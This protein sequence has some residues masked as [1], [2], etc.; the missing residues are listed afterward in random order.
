MSVNAS[1]SASDRINALLDDASFVEVGSF[2][3]AR[4]TDFNLDSV[5][6][7]KDGVITGYGLINGRLVYVYSQDRSVLSGS[8]GEMHAKKIAKLYD[9]AMKMGAPVIGLIDCA[10]L[11][12]R[13]ATDALN[14]FGRLYMKQTMASGVVPQITAILG[15]CGGGVAVVPTLTDFTFISEESGKLFVNSPN[16]LDGNYTEKLDTAS[17]DYISRNTSLVDK[18]LKTDA[19]VL[20][21]IRSFID[22]LPSNCDEEGF[23][24]S[25]DDLNRTI[26]NLDSLKD[27][28]RAVIQ[29][30]ADDNLFYEIKEHFAPEMVTGFVRLNGFTTGVVANQVKDGSD[31]LTSA[32]MQKAARFVNFCDSFNVPVLTFTNVKGFTA[33]IDEEKTAA[34]AAARLIQTFANATV[35]KVNVITGV[36]YG[37]AFTAMNSKSVGADIVY[38]WPNAKVGMMDAEMAAKIIYDEEIKAADDKS[39]AV[40]DYKKQYEDIQ[41]SALSAARRGYVDD[42][43]EP[44]ATRKRVVAAFEMLSTKIEERPYKK[45]VS[46]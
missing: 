39:K 30:I 21:E 38:A 17:A 41:G 4:S 12:L 44:D 31:M 14:A 15:T 22:F 24:D 32:G 20:A 46:I 16:T 13:E 3:T 40:A 45:H 36:A 2:I 29:N 33:T 25:E 6:T 10:G 43:I 19:E 7:P 18:V 35:P 23:S 37:T 1:M 8:I 11:R 27:D 42:I 5:D 28:A 26:P 34:E 9:M